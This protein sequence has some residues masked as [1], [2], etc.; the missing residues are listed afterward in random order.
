MCFLAN[1]NELLNPK[2]YKSNCITIS[3]CTVLD[4]LIF[5][6]SMIPLFLEIKCHKKSM[7]FLWTRNL[8]QFT[9]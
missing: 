1:N 5:S 6:K 8:P 2:G 3:I 7:C 9:N 4:I